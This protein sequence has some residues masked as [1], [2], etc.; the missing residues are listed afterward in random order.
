PEL[1]ELRSQLDYLLERNS[2]SPARP[3]SQRPFC[4]CPKKTEG[5]EYALITGRLIEEPS[6]LVTHSHARTIFLNQL[7]G[8]RFFS[9][10]DLRGSYNQIRVF[11]DDCHKTALRTR[12]GSY[13]YTMMPFGLTN[14]PSTS[15]LT[16]KWPGLLQSLEPPQKPQQHVMMDFVT[17][18]PVSASGNDAVLVVVDRLTK[19]AHFA[20]YR[21]T[22]TVEE[23]AKLF[24]STVVHLHGL[25]LA[26][27]SDRDRK[28]TS[29]FWHETWEQ[30]ST[31]LL[32]SSAYHPQT[33]GQ[34]KRTN[35]TMEQLIRTNCPNPSR[36]EEFLPM[37]E[38]FYND[39][40]S[41][42]TNHSPL[43]LNYGMDPMRPRMT[44]IENPSKIPTRH[45]CM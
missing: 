26:I 14:A 37:L 32:F 21:T 17:G 28:F 43:F 10:I 3:C 23:T 33:D 19:M 34:T 12:Y 22:I 20:P 13:E 38:C 18:L 25:P 45:A 44:N 41:A 24:I 31:R 35:Q 5:S 39:A 2:F 8:A 7:R 16:M 1:T 36:W 27:I 29:K 30:H 6:N 9:K 40:P 15:Q 11:A 42:T 4:S